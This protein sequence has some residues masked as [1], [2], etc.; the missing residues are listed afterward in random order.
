MQTMFQL[1]ETQMAASRAALYRYGNTSSASIWYEL[2]YHE[3]TGH[4]HRG[5]RVWQIAFGSGFKCNSAVWVARGC[6]K[7]PTEFC[8]DSENLWR[9]E[10]VIGKKDVISQEEAARDYAAEDAASA[11]L[12]SKSDL[13]AVLL[14][15]GGLVSVNERDVGQVVEIE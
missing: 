6:S 2:A 11:E 1:D 9:W 14:K 13:E 10:R 15:Y 4:V 3:Q 5:S 8:S 12:Q 7:A